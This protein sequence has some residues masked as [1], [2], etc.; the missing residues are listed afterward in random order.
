MV[1]LCLFKPVSVE[2]NTVMI[3]T[4]SGTAQGGVLGTACTNRWVFVVFELE[5]HVQTGG[6]LL[7]FFS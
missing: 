1:D 4:G 7:Q 5:Q 3:I 2:V 6:F